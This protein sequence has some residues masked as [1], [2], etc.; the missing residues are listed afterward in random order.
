M[1][2]CTDRH[3]IGCQMFDL[4]FFHCFYSLM[5]LC[6]YLSMSLVLLCCLMSMA[7]PYSFPGFTDLLKTAFKGN[8]TF[9]HLS[10]IKVKACNVLK[11]GANTVLFPITAL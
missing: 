8:S 1:F 3:W 7:L 11:K 9:I 6:V 10:I 5:K 4:I 2:S